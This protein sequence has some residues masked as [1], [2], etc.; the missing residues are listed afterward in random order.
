M[1]IVLTKQERELFDLI[2][3]VAK[4][5]VIDGETVTPRVAGG[6]VR[7]KIL[8]INSSDIDITLDKISGYEFA[9]KL[10]NEFKDKKKHLPK[11]NIIQANPEKSKHLETAIVRIYDI[12]VDFANLRSEQYNN[13]RI[14]IISNGTPTEDAERRDLTINSLF[15]NIITNEIEDFTGRGKTDLKKG[16]LDTPVDP[17]ITFNDDPLRILRI[18][19]FYAKFKY[20]ITDRIVEAIK[21]SSIRDAFAKKI[22][23]ERVYQELNKMLSYENGL[24]G[25][26]KIIELEF[27]E[28]IL[29]I[30]CSKF[31]FDFVKVQCFD[32]ITE[33]DLKTDKRLLGFSLLVYPLIVTK[34]VDENLNPDSVLKNALKCDKSLF[35]SI[36]IIR[37]NILFLYEKLKNKQKLDYSDII[38]IIL[39]CKE[40][41]KESM[42]FSYIKTKDVRISNII[43]LIKHENLLEILKIK[44]LLNGKDFKK[45]VEKD[46]IGEYL[47]KS[48]RIQILYEITDKKE[49]LSKVLHDHQENCVL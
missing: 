16:I 18:I 31:D 36:K 11:V 22:S 39:T 48:I 27:Y 34:I 37:E 9:T 15:Y 2:S 8:K 3:K 32:M 41:I 13:S 4:T 44:P 21:I 17:L 6:W 45:R 43:E 25:I 40:H 33:I 7:D 20:T 38:D 49:L 5:I 35:K 14:P 46:K 23:C 24:L 47:K 19:R 1:I 29:K 28:P 12:C 10:V 26:E 30:D 42:L